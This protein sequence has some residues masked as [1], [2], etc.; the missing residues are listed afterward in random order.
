MNEVISSECW[1]RVDIRY[2]ECERYKLPPTLTIDNA[3][4][5]SITLGQLVKEVHAHVGLHVEA[6]ERAKGMFDRKPSAVTEDSIM[7][8]TVGDGDKP[9]LP[10]NIGFFV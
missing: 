6:L 4:G 2:E 9:D 1:K 5:T 10:L 7:S 8:I 3:D